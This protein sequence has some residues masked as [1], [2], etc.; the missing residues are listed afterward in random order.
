MQVFSCFQWWSD[1]FVLKIWCC[2]PNIHFSDWQNKCKYPSHPVLSDPCLFEWNR[3]VV[4][5]IVIKSMCSNCPFD[6]V[7]VSSV[8]PR[9]TCLALPCQ[10]IQH[11]HRLCCDLGGYE[12]GRPCIVLRRHMSANLPSDTWD[13]LLCMMVQSMLFLWKDV[14]ATGLIGVEMTL[15]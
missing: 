5:T 13:S 9:G 3:F 11:W 4:A 1:W 15:T 10:H 8:L 14:L 12:A 2:I 6:R 7:M